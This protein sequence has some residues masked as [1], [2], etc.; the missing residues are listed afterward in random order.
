[1]APLAVS[2]EFSA[3]DPVAAENMPQVLIE[4]GFL[5]D[6]S[7]ELVTIHREKEESAITFV[8]TNRGIWTDAKEILFINFICLVKQLTC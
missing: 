5:S 8:K 2:L 6:P 7:A 4:L 3:R 1:L